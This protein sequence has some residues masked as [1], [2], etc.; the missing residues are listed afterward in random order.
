MV[1]HFTAGAMY[2]SLQLAVTAVS[3]TTSGEVFD[4]K[5]NMLV[6]L[7]AG[8]VCTSLQLALAPVSKTTA[9]L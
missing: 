2:T 5:H 8:V 9:W 4:I 6:Q 3:M 7:T 1:L